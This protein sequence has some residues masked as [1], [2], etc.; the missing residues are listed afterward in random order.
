[1]QRR[2]AANRDML[3]KWQEDSSEQ[4][5]EEIPQSNIKTEPQEETAQLVQKVLQL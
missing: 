5:F 4:E 1:M 2:I 3:R